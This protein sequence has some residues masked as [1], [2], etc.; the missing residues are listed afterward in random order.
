MKIAIVTPSNGYYLKSHRCLNAK[1]H[2]YRRWV[3]ELVNK[4][5]HQCDYI[6]N[7]DLV[8][9]KIVNYDAIFLD[10]WSES[11]TYEKRVQR[12]EE[13]CDLWR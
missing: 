3:Y 10:I 6:G 2:P 9:D 8:A 4:L 7:A 12:D 5:G 1:I 11:K 13:P